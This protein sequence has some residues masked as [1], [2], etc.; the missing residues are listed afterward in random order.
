MKN[1]LLLF[2]L[3]AL[4]MI[5]T[6]SKASASNVAITTTYPESKTIQT[7][8]NRPV[9]VW[10]Y[11]YD[12]RTGESICQGNGFVRSENGKLII[13]VPGKG[14]YYVTN[15]NL[16]GYRYMFNM[17]RFDGTYANLYFNL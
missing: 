14:D 10:Y 12:Y 6:I 1:T 3:F 13:Y 5:S 9:E 17:K 7:N 4:A 15:S 11:Y 8:D 2:C 16:Q